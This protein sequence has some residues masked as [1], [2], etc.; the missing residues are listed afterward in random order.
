MSGKVDMKVLTQIARMYYEEEMTQEAIAKEMNMSRSLVSKLLTKARDK[1]VVKITI[2]E[3]V[4]H[5]FQ[6]MEKQ[7]QKIFGLTGIIVVEGDHETSRQKIAEE[8]GRYLLRR[9]S[10]VTT[11][12]VSAGRM[13][14]E[15]ADSLPVGKSYFHVNF[16]PMSGGLSEEQSKV[17]AN[18]VSEV[19][20]MKC[21][22]KNLRMHAP[23]VVDSPDAKEVLERQYFI[24]TVLDAARNADIALVGIGCTFRYAEVREAYLHGYD[25][26]DTLD[27][28][29]IK[30]DLSYNYFDK[31]GNLY[32]C[33]WNHLRMGLDLDE[34]RNI[35]EVICA[36]SEPEKAE[37][38]YIAAKHRLVN[39][40]IINESIA[41]KLLW[42]RARE[43][44]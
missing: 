16:V 12:T 35:P 33:E 25:A 9:L 29:I 36:A 31:N 20:A 40:L 6:E 27:S 43:Y 19:F 26:A 24:R 30:G 1:G 41:Q 34:I 39:T 37:S 17:E 14:R 23:I 10:D 5:P 11:V 8:A 22:A 13:I 42:Y 2:C 4:N 15:I 32:E 18:S 3:E 28:R 44:E 38:I 7:L 21:G